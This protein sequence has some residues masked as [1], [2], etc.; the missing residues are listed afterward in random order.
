MAEVKQNTRNP[1]STIRRRWVQAAGQ[2]RIPQLERMLA[3][4][5][6]SEAAV[7]EPLD[8]S[9]D[10][11]VDE[12]CNALCAACHHDRVNTVRWLLNV[13][14]ANVHFKHSK[15]RSSILECA[16]VSS[17]A[18]VIRVLLSAGAIVS[19]GPGDG[20]TL[21][22]ARQ[23][24]LPGV[25]QL[26]MQHDMNAA[27]N[28]VG[29]NPGRAIYLLP[30][31]YYLFVPPARL[32]DIKPDVGA[33]SALT[34]SDAESKLTNASMHAFIAATNSLATTSAS[35][36][37]NSLVLRDLHTAAVT[38]EGWGGWAATV[39]SCDDFAALRQSDAEVHR[40]LAKIDV[41]NTAGASSSAIC[42]ALRQCEF[43]W[44]E[45][46]KVNSPLLDGLWVAATGYLPSA[47][48]GLLPA[49]SSELEMDSNEM[50]REGVWH[51]LRRLLCRA[52]VPSIDAVRYLLERAQP[53]PHLRHVVILI[54][55]ARGHLDALQEL[56][57]SRDLSQLEFQ[58]ALERGAEAAAFYGQSATLQV[59]LSHRLYSFAGKWSHSRLVHLAALG[60]HVPVL[61]ML[62]NYVDLA[63]EGRCGHTAEWAASAC[64]HVNV[65]QYLK[66][67]GLTRPTIVSDEVVDFPLHVAIDGQYADV[68][69]SWMHEGALVND[70]GA[71]NLPPLMKAAGTGQL[72]V[73]QLLLAHGVNANFHDDGDD[74]VLLAA[75]RRFGN[76]EIVRL[77]LE[78]GATTEENDRRAET[79]LAAETGDVEMLTVLFAAWT[80][81]PPSSKTVSDALQYAVRGDSVEAARFLLE[82][83]AKVN[84][85]LHGKTRS[86]CRALTMRS[87]DMVELLV[88]AGANLV[89]PN[90]RGDTPAL[91]ALYANFIPGFDALLKADEAAGLVAGRDG[92]TPLH[93]AA[94]RGLDDVVTRLLNI[95][96]DVNTLDS[97]CVTPLMLAA[98]K[99]TDDSSAKDV[100]T[101][102]LLLAR[103]ADVNVVEENGHRTALD[104]AIAA[105][106]LSRVQL[107]LQYGATVGA[108]LSRASF[109]SPG[110]LQLLQ[111][112]DSSAVNVVGLGGR[113]AV[114]HAVK[115][116]EDAIKTILA[117]PQ[118]DLNAIDEKGFT[119]LHLA[120]S[121][122]SFFPV[123]MLLLRH[124]G[125]RTDIPNSDGL[126]PLHTAMLRFSLDE[127]RAVV[128]FGGAGLNV[129][130]ATDGQTALHMTA[131]HGDKSPI[132][133]VLLARG[134]AVDA[135]TKDGSTALHLAVTSGNRAGAELLLKHGSDANASDNNEF[136]SLLLAEK[137]LNL[138][139]IQ[140][141]I[142]HGAATDTKYKQGSD[143]LLR[144]VCDGKIEWVRTLLKFP[145]VNVNTVAPD[146][147]TALCCAV[148]L[149]DVSVFQMLLERG[150][151]VN[152]VDAQ[153]WSV[154]AFVTWK[155]RPDMMKRL[156]QHG[157]VNP[158]TKV[159]EDLSALHMACSLDATETIQILLRFPGIDV[160]IAST[161]GRTPLH[162]AA[163]HQN[164][165]A[166]KMLLDA[167]A[168]V[169]A[170][171]TD[172]FTPL[173]VVASA[174]PVK[175]SCATVVELLLQRGAV[176]N[177]RAAKGLTP[178]LMTASNRNV[179]VVR[180]L[181]KRPEVDV[182]DVESESFISVLHYTVAGPSNSERAQILAL[183]LEQQ[184][185]DVNC[186]TR[187]GLTALHVA[188]KGNHE[189]IEPLIRRG[190][191]VFAVTANGQ[192]ALH[193]AAQADDH[194]SVYVLLQFGAALEGR[195]SDGATALL[196]AAQHGA[197]RT[198]QLLLA[199]GADIKVVEYVGFNAVLLAAANGQ[200][201]MV[202]FLVQ[203]YP[204]GL[205]CVDRDESTALHY[206][207]MS[208]NADLLSYL[209][210]YRSNQAAD[211]SPPA[212]QSGAKEPASGS[213]V[214]AVNAPPADS[215]RLDVN[216]RNHHGFSALHVAAGAG[217]ACVSLLLAQGADPSLRNKKEQTPLVVACVR[218]H[219]NVCEM[220]LDA[221]A[222]RDSAVYLPP[223]LVHHA[224]SQGFESLVRRF[225]AL[226]ADVAA[227]DRSGAT[228][229]HL[230]AAQGHAGTVR[231]LVE[232]KANVN[233]V[234]AKGSTALHMAA[235]NG[236]D[237][238]V[239]VLQELGADRSIRDSEG[240]TALD[241]AQINKNDEC[242]DALRVNAVDNSVVAV[243]MDSTPQP[244]PQR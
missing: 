195:A 71:D 12:G 95:G 15:G 77:L 162:V 38:Y 236:A 69:A 149:R 199:H 163:Q 119:P 101:M 55:A 72:G 133:E 51:M 102:T 25:L 126:Y 197:L 187:A 41:L 177:A 224:A 218:N 66:Q 27:L 83:G 182:N 64:G 169:N 104:Y 19:R 93:V 157:G 153:G 92:V 239:R 209:L 233:A 176:A 166:V 132:M 212:I 186:V 142:E 76:S 17:S 9:I 11:F 67:K 180:E 231:V 110:I 138:P 134:V 4:G 227:V 82:R 155:N 49:I 68:A 150:A 216:A 81:S 42:K 145:T 190:A 146:G 148:H 141:L 98:S 7:D 191:D 140:L 173:H 226:S 36:N 87:L 8:E 74:T 179:A 63:V 59:L 174:T 178:L 18:A 45:V 47:L 158:N 33:P 223:F 171:A 131:V 28:V 221:H 34:N 26:L 228:A 219:P 172:R 139:L 122:R 152:S 114:H 241:V 58:L 220:L 73:V 207:T 2:G 86:V 56:L 84:A 96:A 24:G 194:Q 50:L 215:S 54:A 121:A 143:I 111:A 242:V 168:A 30:M 118:A 170:E 204:L 211:S 13:A 37:T 184:R 123:F 229:L 235:T 62:T 230:A 181:L 210:T 57:R 124:P 10:D 23:S 40:L 1:E 88:T 3:S 85:S 5:D 43:T 20:R 164:Y 99:P 136:W 161:S 21:Q 202:K 198:M 193:R 240:R 116:G 135:R 117:C 6:I 225:I 61:D 120:A 208:K 52:Q 39:T 201:G 35:D 232:A 79:V 48:P 14:K 234:D 205:F 192:S 183:L 112:S 206:A 196:F 108:A 128:E 80:Q 16:V 94:K 244:Q 113:T 159:R 29:P 44:E 203:Q 46:T 100:S 70:I 53:I 129:G 103:G 144:A 90:S 125:V 214:P 189:A 105:R 243:S 160:N 213:H 147:E 222:S 109:V 91:V 75:L 185:L 217:S 32:V 127:F 238:V 60:G 130:R 151:D 200:L 188:A 97:N 106:N 154:L 115:W 65:L 89:L 237:E 78:H 175:R 31:M 165:E 167:G 137:S 156:L 22:V 107:L